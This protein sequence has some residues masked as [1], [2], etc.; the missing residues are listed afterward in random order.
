MEEAMMANA[1]GC[2]G[3]VSLNTVAPLR[4]VFA[5]TPGDPLTLD[6]DGLP[7]SSVSVAKIFSRN[8][9][10]DD[11]KDRQLAM[12]L[13]QYGEW[14]IDGPNPVPS[15]PAGAVEFVA[16][17]VEPSDEGF[18]GIGMASRIFSRYFASQT[19]AGEQV[20]QLHGA[21]VPEWFAPIASWDF[22]RSRLPLWVFRMQ[23]PVDES[24][25]SDSVLAPSQPTSAGAPGGIG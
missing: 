12:V 9:E 11:P 5:G 24:A 6:A 16:E 19:I 14:P 10:L 25:S 3:D 17:P 4:L 20:I 2:L 22:K 8:V 13:M 15:D 18:D 7:Q 23:P 1:L 21:P